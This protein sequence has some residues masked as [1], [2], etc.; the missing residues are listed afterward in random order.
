MRY[1]A[2]LFT[3]MF[4]FVLIPSTSTVAQSTGKKP[5]LLNPSSSKATTSSSATTT[6]AKKYLRAL[7]EFF[8]TDDFKKLSATKDK[9][10]LKA[11][12]HQIGI[13]SGY[14]GEALSI[15][16][17]FNDDLK[18]ADHKDKELLELLKGSAAVRK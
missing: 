3:A 16:R 6:R 15:T 10:A 14:T 11:R 5:S 4:L 8:K 9:T 1:V 13:A 18:K 12:I 17:Q 7:T 2:V